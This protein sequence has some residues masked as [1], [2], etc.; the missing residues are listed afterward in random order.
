MSTTSAQDLLT[1]ADL[2]HD[3]ELFFYATLPAMTATA[4]DGVEFWT[5]AGG[6]LL[7]LDDSDTDQNPNSSLGLAS[8]ISLRFPQRDIHAPMGNTQLQGFLRAASRPITTTSGRSIPSHQQTDTSD[9]K[10]ALMNPNIR[11]TRKR[12]RTVA[13]STSRS[14]SNSPSP[15]RSPSPYK[16][17]QNDDL[18]I[19]IAIVDPQTAK[20]QASSFRQNV[21]T[22]SSGGT[23]LRSVL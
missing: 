9:R 13:G 15:E 11:K 10:L 8:Q 6:P 17:G 7:F 18:V 4:S 21:I 20:E 19:P 23:G 14:S 2:V 22:S 1:V 5:A 16:D 12:I 3:L